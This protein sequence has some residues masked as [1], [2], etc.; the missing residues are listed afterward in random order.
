MRVLGIGV[1]MYEANEE[2]KAR[3]EST[4]ETYYTVDGET[5]EIKHRM[6]VR[7]EPR[8]KTKWYWH[9]KS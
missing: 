7:N 9:Y 8:N 6:V 3:L 5:S 1:G 4:E 2:E